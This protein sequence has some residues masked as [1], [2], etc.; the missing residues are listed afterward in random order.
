[1]IETQGIDWLQMGYILNT[2]CSQISLQAQHSTKDVVTQQHRSLITFFKGKHPALPALT[3]WSKH[4]Q[5][6]VVMHDL[7]THKSPRWAGHPEVGNPPQAHPS[8]YHHL[9]S[10]TREPVC[11]SSEYQEAVPLKWP[12]TI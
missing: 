8:I 5:E 9:T 6:V 11:F 12:S 10:A 3:V 7:E 4:I 2:S 1:M